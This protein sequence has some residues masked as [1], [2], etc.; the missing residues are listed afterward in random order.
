MG[1]QFILHI[2]IYMGIFELEGN[3]KVCALI[4]VYL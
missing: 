4:H 3:I 1:L 2:M